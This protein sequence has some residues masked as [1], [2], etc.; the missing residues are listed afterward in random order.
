M[1]QLSCKTAKKLLLPIDGDDEKINA[2]EKAG[3]WR[4]KASGKSP[5]RDQSAIVQYKDSGGKQAGGQR[6]KEMAAP[7]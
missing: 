3:G 2:I 1:C 5:A 6:E 4:W 7:G